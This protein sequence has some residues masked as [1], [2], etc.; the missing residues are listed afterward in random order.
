M[1]SIAKIQIQDIRFLTD[2]AIAAPVMVCSHERS[3]T[4]FLMN[5]I[6]RNSA[7][8]NDPWLD[9]DYD[10]LG[11]FHN[12]HDCKAVKSLFGR[13]SEDKCASI[14]KS[15]F[16]ASF[17]VGEENEFLLPGL[18]KTLYIARNPIDVML[19][20]RRYVEYCAW[21][22]GPRAK[23]VA[24][25]FNAAPRARMLRY[26]SSENGSILE[27]WKKNFLGWLDLAAA[28][29][30]HVLVVKYDDLDRDHANETRRVLDFL[31]CKAPET[32]ARPSRFFQIIYVPPVAPLPPGERELLR[33]AIAEKLGFCEPVAV[34]FPEL[35]T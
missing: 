12:F 19:S 23:S 25:F 9:Y 30:E 26:Q 11:S 13:L 27:R 21:D 28:N 14:I 7:F 15:H 35:Y 2:P 33:R 5:S 22:E 20:F 34:M 29:R 3:G 18:C 8:H 6:A 17:F 10:P 31:G 4:H 1:G 24:D 16:A 32:I